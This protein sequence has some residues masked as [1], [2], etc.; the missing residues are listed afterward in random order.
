[1]FGCPRWPQ[2]DTAPHMAQTQG[3]KYFGLTTYYDE[4][5]KF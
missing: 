4:N 3:P 5:C 1:M 2:C